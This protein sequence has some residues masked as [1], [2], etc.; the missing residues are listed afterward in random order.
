LN[1]GFAVAG[2][3][4]FLPRFFVR[5]SLSLSQHKSLIASFGEID[6][7]EEEEELRW[8]V[9]QMALIYPLI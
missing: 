2:L 6:R 1:D 4:F 7:E 8:N 3:L 5:F 9:G